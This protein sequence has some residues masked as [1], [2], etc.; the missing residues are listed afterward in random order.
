MPWVVLLLDDVEAW[1]F[2]LDAIAMAAVTGAID[3]LVRQEHSDRR[4][5]IRE[6]A[7]RR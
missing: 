7:G 1:Y 5:S 6:L 4:T 3:L 2:D